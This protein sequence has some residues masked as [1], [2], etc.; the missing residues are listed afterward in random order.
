MIR[1]PFFASSVSSIVPT[2]ADCQEKTAEKKAAQA[3]SID[4]N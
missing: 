4:E 2:P 1:P 3:A